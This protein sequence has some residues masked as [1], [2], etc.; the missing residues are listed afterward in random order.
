MASRYV[1]GKCAGGAAMACDRGRSSTSKL[2]KAD[3][4]RDAAARLRDMAEGE[5]I[6]RLQTLLLDLAD[7]H[8]ELAEMFQAR[9]LPPTPRGTLGQSTP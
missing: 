1:A 7:Q 6:G 9:C 2:H 8:E 5:P 3:H 4:Y